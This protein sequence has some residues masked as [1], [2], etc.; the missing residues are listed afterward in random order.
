MGIGPC[1][2][3]SGDRLDGPTLYEL[4]GDWSWTDDYH[5]AQLEVDPG[6]PRSFTVN[7]FSTGDALYVGAVRARDQR[8]PATVTEHPEVRIRIAGHVVEAL[9]HEV[10]ETAERDRA[11]AA[12]ASKYEGDLLAPALG[13]PGDALVFRLEPVPSDRRPPARD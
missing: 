4:P 7:F 10:D 9:A 2:P 11:L 6:S 12:R 5:R 3:I 1:G 13:E 8:W